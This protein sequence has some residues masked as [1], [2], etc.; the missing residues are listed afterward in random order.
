MKFRCPQCGTGYELPLSV[1]PKPA[2]QESEEQSPSKMRCVRCKCIFMMSVGFAT[3]NEQE[4]GDKDVYFEFI[5]PA[6]LPEMDAVASASTGGAHRVKYALHKVLE[7]K[8]GGE[9]VS[10]TSAWN[11][12]STLDLS[13]YAINS[14]KRAA[15]YKSGF[16]GIIAFLAIGFVVYVAAMND[17]TIS[18]NTFEKQLK[19]AF[20]LQTEVDK[21][22]DLLLQMSV[23]LKKGYTLR[24]RKGK[25]IGVIRGEIQ[26]NAPIDVEHVTLEG[27]IL[28]ST[29]KVVKS[30]VVPCSLAASDARLRT[31]RKK[32]LHHIYQE[33]GKPLN[34]QVKSGYST[35]FKVVFDELPEYFNSTYIFEVHPKNVRP[36]KNK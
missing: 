11:A 6:M 1:L 32:D 7:N 3:P 15:R 30:V 26:N 5:S 18:I 17:W 19:K 25:T 36:A 2:K 8:S 35:V 14:F 31:M 13:D 24:I 16:A 27:R 29:K 34:C 10:K 33:Q 21:E 9:V 4:T 23:S 28:D 12:Q 22:A 20:F